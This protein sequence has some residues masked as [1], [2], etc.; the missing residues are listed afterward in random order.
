M[1]GVTLSCALRFTSMLLLLVVSVNEK[2]IVSYIHFFLFKH[3]S[4]SAL[5][6]FV[7]K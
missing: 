6:S 5:L 3:C 1:R 7:R 2:A 4:G